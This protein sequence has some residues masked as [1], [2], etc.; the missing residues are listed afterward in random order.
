M[1]LEMG[2]EGIRKGIYSF[3]VGGIYGEFE[4]SYAVTFHIR[5]D[6]GKYP[7]AILMGIIEGPVKQG[8]V[9]AVLPMAI[10][11][12]HPYAAGFHTAVLHCAEPAAHIGVGLA[13][14]NENL[15]A[16]KGNIPGLH[17]Y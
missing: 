14:L 13:W 1:I 17:S 11:F 10:G 7:Y 15:G 6:C 3:F 4:S 8:E 16:Y 9:P 5:E 12:K 2:H